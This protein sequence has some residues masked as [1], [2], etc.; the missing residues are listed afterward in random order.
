[1]R[2]KGCPIETVEMKGL[3]HCSM[4]AFRTSLTLTDTVVA[5]AWEPKGNR[6][7]YSSTND[8]AF[9]AMG[10][11]STPKTSLSFYQLDTRKGDFRLLSELR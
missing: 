11:G 2:D 3:F 8:P 7:V 9:A 10:P 6:F 4:G 5:F 1:M